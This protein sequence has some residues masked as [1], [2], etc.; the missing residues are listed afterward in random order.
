LPGLLTPQ[1]CIRVDI[2]IRNRVFR[3]NPVSY[4]D[5]QLA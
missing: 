5:S 4:N 1:R 2:I 3:K